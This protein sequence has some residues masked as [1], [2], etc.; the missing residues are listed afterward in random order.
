[1]VFSFVSPHH[2]VFEEIGKMAGAL[3]YIHAIVLVNI[4]R[5]AHAVNAFKE[6]VRT[7]ENLYKEKRQPTGFIGY[8]HDDWF[9]QRILDLFTLASADA[10]AMLVNINSLREMLPA[11]T[12]DTHLPHEDHEYRIRRRSPFTII[13]GVIGTLMGWFTQRWLNNLRDRME[14]V[15][16]QQHRLLHVQAVQ[17]QCLEEV[18]S[19]IKQLYQSLKK[20]HTAWI[21]YSSLD[22]A[23]DQLQ[24]NLQKLI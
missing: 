17:L 1:L 3:S 7:L 14:E 23:R 6:D 15:E 18:E 22:Y 21:S 9:N 5:L 2:V 13:G 24:A 20:G 16:D 8:S 12:A 19:A 10:D 4:S 11:A